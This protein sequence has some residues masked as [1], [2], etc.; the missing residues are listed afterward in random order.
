MKFH[1]DEHAKICTSS[2]MC[3][4]QLIYRQYIYD[5]PPVKRIFLQNQADLVVDSW[6]FFRCH[7]LHFSGQETTHIRVRANLTCVSPAP[8]PTRQAEC[9]NRQIPL[10]F[11]IILIRKRKEMG[12]KEKVPL[13]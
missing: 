13:Q 12:R 4:D 1:A 5:K 7:D 3:N 2:S 10:G 9:R 6:F 8:G 11:S